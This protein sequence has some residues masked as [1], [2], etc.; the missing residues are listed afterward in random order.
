M[1]NSL[2]RSSLRPLIRLGSWRCRNGLFATRSDEVCARRISSKHRSSPN[3]R[4]CRSNCSASYLFLQGQLRI[5]SRW[6]LCQHRIRWPGDE[7][8]P[9]GTTCNWAPYKAHFGWKAKGYK[10]SH[11]LGRWFN[12]IRSDGWLI[13]TARGNHAEGHANDG[14][15][16]PDE[17]RESRP[18]CLRLH[19]WPANGNVILN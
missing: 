18:S 17:P 5:P 3:Q 2:H 7:W 4:C 10:V 9:S 12:A 14:P 6:V 13:S 11:R 1:A 19:R 8:K 15:S 16:R